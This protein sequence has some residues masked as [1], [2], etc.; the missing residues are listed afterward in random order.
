MKIRNFKEW[1]LLNERSGVVRGAGKQALYPPQYVCGVYPPG[2]WINFSADS[3][4][5]M[6]E[7]DRHLKF[8]W[9]KGML[10]NPQGER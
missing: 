10:S 6:P 2:S 1:L 5:Y 3:I 8:I 9:G 7:K 4:T